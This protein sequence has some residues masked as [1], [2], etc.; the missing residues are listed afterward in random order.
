VPPALAQ[1]AAVF[2]AFTSWAKADPAKASAKVRANIEMRVFMTFS[3][4]RW[5]L[6]PRPLNALCEA[7]V[8]QE[9]PILS[10][11]ESVSTSISPPGWQKPPCLRAC[12][13]ASC[14]PNLTNFKLDEKRSA[15][16]ELCSW[17]GNGVAM[18]AQMPGDP[19][20]CRQ[21]ALNCMLLAKEATTA[22]SKQTFQNLATAFPINSGA[23]CNS[24][25]S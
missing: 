15:G 25:G 7:Y 23:R 21:H 5:L 14:V 20:K 17:T 10:R 6:E 13:R 22:Q 3:P 16:I 24:A 9:H 8:P 19:K 1:S 4:L 11:L 12:G 2:A 18:E